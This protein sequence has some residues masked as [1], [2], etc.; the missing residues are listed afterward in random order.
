MIKVIQ[1]KVLIYCSRSVLDVS[2]IKCQNLWQDIYEKTFRDLGSG[3]DGLLAQLVERMTL[4]HHV[5]GS[6]PTQSTPL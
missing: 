6:I 5:V 4:N 1:R 3:F 2:K